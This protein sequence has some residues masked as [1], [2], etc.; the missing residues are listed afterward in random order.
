M[1]LESTADATI[2]NNF[3]SQDKLALNILL[4][5]LEASNQSTIA[6]QNYF[7]K[8]AQIE[9]AYGNQLLEL[10]ESSHQIEECFSTILTSSEMSARAHVDL[11]QY[12][13][14]MLELPLKNYLAD[15]ENIKM[16]VTY[17]KNKM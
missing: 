13:R 10:A 15:Q 16:F 2:E 14:N 4:G 12:I 8:R 9:E 3:W 5:K 6:I 1:L 11:G 17:E 7:A